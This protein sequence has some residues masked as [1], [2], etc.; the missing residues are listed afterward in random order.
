MVNSVSSAFSLMAPT[1]TILPRLTPTSALNH[2][3]PAPVKTLPFLMAKSSIINPD[4][5]WAEV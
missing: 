3:L 1:L 4:I 5:Y 2:G